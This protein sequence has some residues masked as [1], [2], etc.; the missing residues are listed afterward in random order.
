MFVTFFSLFM[1][2]FSYSNG[3]KFDFVLRL[4]LLLC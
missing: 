4:V 3:D 2:N 1:N